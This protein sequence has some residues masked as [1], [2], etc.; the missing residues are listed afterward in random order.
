MGTDENDE[1]SATAE[2]P[3]KARLAKGRA[4]LPTCHQRSVAN[5]CHR[6]SAQPAEGPHDGAIYSGA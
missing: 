6:L 2:K 1:S 5:V 4:W 3:N